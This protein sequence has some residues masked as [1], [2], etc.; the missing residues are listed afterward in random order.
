MAERSVETGLAS[1]RRDGRPVYTATPSHTHPNG[2]TLV[3]K[4]RFWLVLASFATALALGIYFW[5]RPALK[6]V[7]TP[8]APKAHVKAPSR[9]VAVELAGVTLDTVIE[10]IQAVG[11]LQPNEA[12][13]VVPEI[14]GRIDRIAFTEGQ[15]VTAG[16]VLVELDAVI[17]KAELAKARAD[18]TLTRS[19][20]ERNLKLA[21]QGMGTLRARDEAKGALDAAQ[22]S[23][24]LAVAR[25]Q[26]AT[27]RAPLSGLV[28]LRAVSAGAYVTAG[29]RIVDLTS[30]HPL[31][32]DFRVPELSLADVRRGQVVKVTLDALAGRG[33]DGEIYAIDPVVDVAGRAIRIRARVPNPNGELSPGLFARVQVV[34][35][36]RESALLIPESAVFAREDKHFVYRVVDGHAQRTAVVL[37]QRRPGFVEVRSGL[38]RDARVV[39]AGQQQV[40]DG[41]PLQVA[42]PAAS[43]AT[44]GG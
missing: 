17:L 12:V 11:T 15:A 44:E 28:G 9:P 27:L 3:A 26:K 24:E 41:A 36:R 40:R 21:T 7:T 30:V 39:T 16:D 18:L 22:A 19:N 8:E 2:V 14:A 6:A 29:Q 35:A 37:G 32:L 34:V 1:S 43:T 10:Q 31:K 4:L 33:F 13:T 23:L 42:E 20:Y 5:Q 25:L 38:T